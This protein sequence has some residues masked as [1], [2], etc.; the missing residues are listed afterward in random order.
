MFRVDASRQHWIPLIR[1]NQDLNTEV[2]VYICDL[3]FNQN[4]LV[5]IGNKKRLKI[6]AARELG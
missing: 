4:H 1:A 5:K 6:D 2:D 3:H